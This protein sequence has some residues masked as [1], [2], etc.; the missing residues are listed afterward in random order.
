AVLT[1]ETGEQQLR[2]LPSLITGADDS[3]SVRLTLRSDLQQVVR[4]ALGERE[5]T[6]VV[7]NPR[8]GAVQ[9]LWSYPSF[10]PNQVVDP[11][12]ETAQAVLTFLQ[13]LPGDPLL[14]NTYQQRY[15]PG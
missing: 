8:S 15:M 4:D 10:N 12:F 2:N 11:D 1:G 5:G 9:A 3:G 7:M 13:A 6:V 14:A